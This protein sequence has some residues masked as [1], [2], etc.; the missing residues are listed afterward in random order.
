MANEEVKFRIK[1]NIDGKEKLVEAKTSVKVR[2]II[3]SF[4]TFSVFPFFFCDFLEVK[5][6]FVSLHQR[7]RS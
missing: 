5:I 1:L 4:Y 2:F 6:K 7:F 3:S